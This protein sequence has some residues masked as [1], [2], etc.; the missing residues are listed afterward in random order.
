MYVKLAPL[1]TVKASSTADSSVSVV[2]QVIVIHFAACFSSN[3]QIIAQMIGKKMLK[4]GKFCTNEIVYSLLSYYQVRFQRSIKKSLARGVENSL[5]TIKMIA[6]NTP[7]V[8]HIL[9]KLKS[10]SCIRLSKTLFFT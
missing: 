1:C 6:K 4:K 8:T 5:A 3:R 9:L 7:T 2:R 10:I